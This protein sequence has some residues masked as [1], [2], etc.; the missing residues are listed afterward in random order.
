MPKTAALR[1]AIFEILAK[2]LREG[3]KNAPQARRGLGCF[4]ITRDG[5]GDKHALDDWFHVALRGNVNSQDG[6][7]FFDP[8][9]NLRSFLMNLF[10]TF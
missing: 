6:Y 4:F 9:L 5:Q 2:N 1:A 8:M 7:I 10:Q 3:C